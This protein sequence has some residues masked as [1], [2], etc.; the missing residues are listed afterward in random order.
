MI[1]QALLTFDD[2]PRHDTT[3]IVLDTLAAWAVTAAF[4]V[5]GERL[6]Q[7]AGKRLAERIVS[8]GHLLGNHGFSHRCLLG[9][10]PAVARTELMRAEELIYAAGECRRV[11]RPPYGMCDE[12]L[13]RVA[14]LLGYDILLW[15]V[16]SEDWKLRSAQAWFANVKAQLGKSPTQTVLLHDIHRTTAD[17]IGDLLDYLVS[18]PNL[19]I[20]PAAS[21]HGFVLA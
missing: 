10:A 1:T 4:F 5:V 11:F 16:D 6:I 15:N 17:G 8:E 20:A 14:R 19:V 3:S 13:D 2:G 12:S 7:P 21:W 18:A 9:A